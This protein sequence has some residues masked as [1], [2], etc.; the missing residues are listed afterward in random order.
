MRYSQL[1]VRLCLPTSRQFEGRQ[2]KTQKHK[3]QNK[4]RNQTEPKPKKQKTKNKNK[5]GHAVLAHPRSPRATHHSKR[6]SPFSCMYSMKTRGLKLRP[7][8][9]HRFGTADYFSGPLTSSRGSARPLLTCPGRGDR[10]SSGRPY[11]VKSARRL[12]RTRTRELS[13]ARRAAFFEEL[14]TVARDA[15]HDLRQR[16][17]FSSECTLNPCSCCVGKLA[18]LLQVMKTR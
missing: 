10:A 5:S 16:R 6:F 15:L 17:E 2:N 8:S 18:P 1:S 9:A 13:G 3:T 11:G 12:A 4:T 14:A 7:A